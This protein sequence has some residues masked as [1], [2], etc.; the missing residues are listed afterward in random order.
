MT[1]P[2]STSPRLPATIYRRRLPRPE[3]PRSTTSMTTSIDPTLEAILAS[4]ER[5]TAT[6]PKE[7]T[8]TIKASAASRTRR[9]SQKKYNI[10]QQSK[11]TTR[12]KPPKI[13]L[14]NRK[15]FRPKMPAQ[16]ITSF[17]RP[18]S[19]QNHRKKK[20]ASA[21]AS[22]RPSSRSSNNARSTQRIFQTRSTLLPPPPSS[23]SSSS[24]S[25]PPSSSSTSLPP[26]ASPETNENQKF[27][28]ASIVRNH[29]PDKVL[30]SQVIRDSINSMKAF[31][32]TSD[33]IETIVEGLSHSIP[34]PTPVALKQHKK[35]SYMQSLEQAEETKDNMFTVRLPKHVI[36]AKNEA[37]KLATTMNAIEHGESAHD[38]K[39][40]DNMTRRTN[41]SRCLVRDLRAEDEMLDHKSH[42]KTAGILDRRMK[43]LRD[44]ANQLG[45]EIRVQKKQ[46][47]ERKRRNHL[48][49]LLVEAQTQ[50]HDERTMNVLRTLAHGNEKKALLLVSMTKP[51]EIQPLVKCF[52][53]LEEAKV[54]S[55]HHMR[56]TPTLT[57]ML[58]TIKQQYHQGAL[59]SDALQSALEIVHNRLKEF[60]LLQGMKFFDF[61]FLY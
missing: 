15:K 29:I 2:R 45:M 6:I 11:Q 19:K 23:S 7:M 41:M 42:E 14:D 10:Q 16:A 57:H 43:N 5:F 48:A 8:A 13:L 36:V 3:T 24:S 18:T 46:H 37:R 53:K 54:T 52:T 32:I 22:R 25:S 31:E 60:H 1:R 61:L 39:E 38:K 50:K 28:T 58:S 9:H 27:R 47:D 35:K 4:V 56:Y 30:D 17:A 33:E 40:I 55:I 34:K 12:K 21:S 51:K 49:K 20:P 59:K 26:A 44:Q